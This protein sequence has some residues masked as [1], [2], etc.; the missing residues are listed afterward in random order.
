MRHMRPFL[1]FGLGISVGF[2]VYLRCMRATFILLFSVWFL[3]GTFM[4]GNDAEEFA[5]IPFL[6]EHFEE[7][8]PDGSFPDFIAFI[9]EHYDASMPDGKEHQQLPFGKHLQPCLLFVIPAISI[10][11]EPVSSFLSINPVYP[12]VNTSLLPGFSETWQPPRLS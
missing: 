7:H 4:P 12:E 6:I 3:L 8:S 1:F 9:H 5:K 10:N 2:L 11:V